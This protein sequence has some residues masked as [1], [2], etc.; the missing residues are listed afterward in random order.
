MTTTF[1]LSRPEAIA[2]D[3][4]TVADLLDR[5]GGIPAS[6]VRM[7]PTPGTATEDDAIAAES[8]FGRLCELVEGTLVEKPVG[9]YESIIAG[10]ISR[11]LGEFV[12]PRRLGVVAGEQGMMRVVPGR[13]RMPDV[14]FTSWPRVP[15]DFVSDAAPR[16]SPDLAIEVLSA[17]NT[18]AEMDS[19]R[20]EYFAGGTRLVWLVDPRDRTFAVYRP[21]AA[22]PVMFGAG[23]VVDGGDVLPGFALDVADV[24]AQAERPTA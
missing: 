3:R 22:D 14:S 19:K 23:D 13:V 1:D 5:L 10:V 2:A 18:V 11:M 20:A 12:V 16:V 9:F 4:D 15:A 6:R 8:Q 21:G 7:H 17:G 24:F